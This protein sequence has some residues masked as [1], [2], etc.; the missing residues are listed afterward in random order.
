MKTLAIIQARMSSTRLPGKVLLP[1]I[2]DFRVLDSV[3]HRIKK[4]EV[5]DVII[6]TSI[7]FSDDAILSFCESR[8]YKVERG[9]LDDVLERYY[10]IAKKY[11]ADI[12]VRVTADCPLVDIELS[13]IIIEKLK[14]NSLDYVGVKSDTIALGLS[15][16]VFSFE[17]LQKA[18]ILA[19][20]PHR[21]HVTSYIYN[22]PD[23]F[24]VERVM[25]PINY[26][27][28]CG[29]RLT[30]DVKE[31][32]EVL[33][34]IFENTSEDVKISEVISYLNKNPDIAIMNSGIVQKGVFD[35]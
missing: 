11:D 21:E 12:I 25:S 22:H 30:L 16:E 10:N 2:G 5:D 23:K 8:G 33:K 4:A 29:Y 1:L 19:K 26:R 14:A 28:T 34:N 24:K 20:G 15:T 31:D 9:S 3:Y 6:G 13:N 7:D 35:K 18:Y 32:Y 27:L 17:A